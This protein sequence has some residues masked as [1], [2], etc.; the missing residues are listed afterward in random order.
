MRPHNNASRDES[1]NFRMITSPKATRTL[2]VLMC[3]AI[4]A[5]AVVVRPYAARRGIA[6]A[7]QE[8]AERSKSSRQQK[9]PQPEKLPD[10]SQQQT[11]A[12]A[13]DDEDDP[14]LP[15]FANGKVNKEEYLKARDEQ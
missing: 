9:R 1:T 14:D 4:F 13:A 8:T 5:A 10:N 11:T 12:A 3:L 6:Y 15:A 2:F 7:Q